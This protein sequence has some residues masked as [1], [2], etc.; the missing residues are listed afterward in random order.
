MGVLD[1]MQAVV[2]G[3]AYLIL[4]FI[5]FGLWGFGIVA[6]LILIYLFFFKRK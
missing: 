5:F 2:G 3:I 6:G 4:A 1:F